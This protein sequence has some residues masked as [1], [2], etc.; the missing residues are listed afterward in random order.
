LKVDV[1]GSGVRKG[2]GAAGNIF[3]VP[4]VHAAPDIKAS[5]EFA[6]TL[7]ASSIDNIHDKMLHLIDNIREQGERLNRRKRLED[8]KYYRCLVSEYMQ[9]A[10]DAIL[11]FDTETV[12]GFGHPGVTYGI[13][14]TVNQHLDKLTREVL[15]EESEVL[16]LLHELD[17]IR[18]L[19]MNLLV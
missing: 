6:K 10:V 9:V 4:A 7:A 18:G 1:K 2:T 3:I 5:Q 8:L 12:S 16:D 11:K 15:S 19:L 14:A 13:V 17:E